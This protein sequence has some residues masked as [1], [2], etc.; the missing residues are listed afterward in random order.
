MNSNPS[1]QVALVT[2]ASAG[3]GDAT[4]RSLLTTGTTVYAAARRVER[5]APLAA[6]GARVVA[7]D[8]TDD[9]ALIGAIDRIRDEAG[10][11][12]VLV[13]NAGYGSYGAIEDVPLTEARRQFEVNVFAAAR[14]IQ[15]ALPMMRAQRSGTIVNVSSMGGKMYEP[16]GGW[17]HATK[18]ALEGLSDC[19]RLELAPFGVRV[20]IIEPGGIKTEWG[21]IAVESLLQRSG[22]TAYGTCATAWAKFLKTG[23]AGGSDA[24]VIADVIVRAVRSKRPKIRYVAGALAA[25]ILAARCVLPDRAFDGLMS[26]LGRYAKGS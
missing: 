17:Y 12:D 14:L 13:N 24:S 9:E 16:F 15:L 23:D 10:R 2:G 19:L 20:V 7:L 5:M 18:F 11:L 26:F 8:V 4:V 22:S 25:P 3:I 6:L 1:S 21:G